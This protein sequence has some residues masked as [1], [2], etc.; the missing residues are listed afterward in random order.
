MDFTTKLRQERS[1]QYSGKVNI[2]AVR[3]LKHHHF[4][5]V[6]RFLDGD[7]PK[8]YIRAYFHER[9]RR[10]AGRPRCWPGYFAKF[11][12]KSYPHESVIEFL[13]NQVGIALGLNMNEVELVMVNGHLRFLSKDFVGRGQKLVHG[14]EIL[15]EYF[16]DRTFVEEIN[17]NRK[18]RREYLTFDEVEQAIIHVYP[19]ASAHLLAELVKLITF[20]AVV[21]NND[22]HFHNWGVIDFVERVEGQNVKFA[23]VYDSAR[24]LLW[25]K[26]TDAV[27]Q[28]LRKNLTG[29]RQIHHFVNKTK[30]RFSPPNEPKA[31]HFQLIRYLSRYN[32]TYR[33]IIDSLLTHDIEQAALETLRSFAQPLLCDERCQM[34]EKVLTLRFQ[35]CRKFLSDESL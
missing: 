13:I 31:D 24:A 10:Q 4:Y 3:V 35:T 19:K 8:E 22:R 14:I 32:T 21:G 27:R 2:R 28:M 16:E 25:N 5:V 23:P 26:K 20:D 12:G 6:P 18:T 1:N 34:M 30:P 9:G 7:Q 29:D 33:D 15:A 17:A 11:G